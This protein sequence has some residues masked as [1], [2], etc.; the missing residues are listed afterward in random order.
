MSV[1]NKRSIPKALGTSGQQNFP[2][3]MK[4]TQSPQ[5][6]N[7]EEK[8]PNEQMSMEMVESGTKN[9]EV[10]IG[11]MLQSEGISRD[12]N[13]K[14]HVFDKTPGAVY[15]SKEDLENQYDV[16]GSLAM[17]EI[18]DLIPKVERIS[19]H[20]SSLFSV[21]DIENK[22]LNITM[23]DE[24]NVSEIKFHYENISAS[25]KVKFH[26]NTSDT[27]YIDY[28]S[29]SL[30]V[31]RMKTHTLKLEGQLRQEKSPIRACQTQVKR[32]EYEDPQGVKASL[33]EKDNMIQSMK[34]R[35]NMSAT[36]HPKT[37]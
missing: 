16:K 2:K 20:K 28:P 8:E 1:Y 6:V 36:E 19:Q 15:Q 22:T 34:K 9:E 13:N 26:R 4:I 21:R 12:F 3:K 35:L 11:S 24:D 14:K 27:L 32:L 5:I 33:E 30:R 37:T 23:E 31:S 7:L 17:S 25:N 10:G 29:P 18:R